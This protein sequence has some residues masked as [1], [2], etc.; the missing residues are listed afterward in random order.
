MLMHNKHQHARR[1]ARLF[2]LNPYVL[3]KTTF[4]QIPSNGPCCTLIGQ[5]A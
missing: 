5:M 4:L 1:D 3:T 2:P